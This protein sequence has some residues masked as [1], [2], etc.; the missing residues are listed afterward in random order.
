MNATAEGWL[1][2]WGCVAAL[3]M[4]FILGSLAWARV[5]H[6]L[7]GAQPQPARPA[8][9]YPKPRRHEPGPCWCGDEHAGRLAGDGEPAWRAS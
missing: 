3:G 2:A 7:P 6:K 5:T 8:S 4:L 1:A 9:E